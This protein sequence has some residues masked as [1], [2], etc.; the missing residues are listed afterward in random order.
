MSLI[1]RL[2]RCEKKINH[3]ADNNDII[4]KDVVIGIDIGGTNTAIG[5]VDEKGT[6]LA[7]SNIKTTDFAEVVGFVDALA[8]EFSKLVD[9]RFN[10]KAI[11]IGAPNGN[12]NRGTIEDAPNLGWPGIIPFAE[13]IEKKVGVKAVLTNDANAA[14][15]GEQLFGGAKGMSDFFVFTLGTGLGSGIVVNGDVVYGYTGFAGECGHMIMDPAGRQ[16]NCG[17]RGCLEQYVSAPGIVTTVQLLLK[18]SDNTSELR[19]INPEEITSKNIAEAAERGDKLALEAFDFTAELLARAIAN[20]AVVTSPEAVFLFGGL[21]N[22][23]DLLL[24]PVRKYF[25]NYIFP[26]LQNKVKIL[27]SGIQEDNAAVLGSAALAWKEL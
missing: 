20:T 22:A 7:D 1:L 5:V 19:N 13:M 15:L 24:V 21:A 6:V 9:N 14:A 25:D 12:Y 2:T 8:A 26:L 17:R 3:L 16:C 11:G 10:L 4:M 27:L 18:E 23:G